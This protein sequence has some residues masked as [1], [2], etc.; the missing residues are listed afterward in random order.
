MNQNNIIKEWMNKPET[1][2]NRIHIAENR[3]ALN[4]PAVRVKE[5]DSW[6]KATRGEED[7]EDSQ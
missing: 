1:S 6:R 2:V 7:M 5:K 3:R 4:L